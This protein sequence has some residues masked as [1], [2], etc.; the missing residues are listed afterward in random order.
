MGIFSKLKID[1][2]LRKDWMKLGDMGREANE[3]GGTLTDEG[4]GGL[5]DSLS[6]YQEGMRDPLGETGRNLF[7]R[8]RGNLTD[9]FTRT[10]ASARTRARQQALQSGGGLTA[11]QI[12][13][14]D[15]ESGRDAE[16]NL[17]RGENEL[18]MGEAEMTLSETNRLRDRI[19]GVQKTI[20]G[21]GQDEKT[22]GVQSIIASLVGRNQ[23]YGAAAGAL[24]QLLSTFVGRTGGR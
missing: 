12:A 2:G 23:R 3:Y 8:A 18:S 4:L 17:F 24:S 19:E 21:V 22:R 20:L 5:R 11:E 6:N 7:A 13:A 10:L 1:K 15:R 16:E 14:L 9:N